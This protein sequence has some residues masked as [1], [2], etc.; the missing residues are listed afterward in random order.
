[1][2]ELSMAYRDVY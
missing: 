1:M 2:G